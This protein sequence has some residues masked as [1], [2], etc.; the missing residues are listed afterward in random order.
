MAY[1]WIGWVF[2]WVSLPATISIDVDNW[3]TIVQFIW[4]FFVRSDPTRYAEVYQDLRLYSLGLIII[5][6]FGTG[7]FAQIYRFRH[8]STIPQRQQT[9]WVVFGLSTAAI[10][11][12][13]ITLIFGST[14]EDQATLIGILLNL[15]G[16]TLLAICYML[17]PLTL[18]ISIL[19]FQLWDVDFLINQTLVYGALT[20]LVSLFYV[21]NVILLQTIFRAVTGETSDVAIV[22]STLVLAAIFQPLRK[23]LQT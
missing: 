16:N 9:K 6:W 19:R 11:Y 4:R 2:A 21:G 18:A 10:G 17:V 3:P 13:L 23:R 1:I 15:G 14:L 20:V 8:V 22:I 5:I 7:V 12:L